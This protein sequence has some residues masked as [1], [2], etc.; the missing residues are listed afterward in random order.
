LLHYY[1]SELV[2]IAI[3]FELGYAFSSCTI[4]N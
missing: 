4:I 1:S 2:I 3:A